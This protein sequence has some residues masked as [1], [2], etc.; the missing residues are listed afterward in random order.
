MTK[1]R[2]SFSRLLYNDKVMMI[3]SLL[4]AIG[5]WVS[6]IS[7]PANIDERTIT[8]KATIDLTNRSDLR[9]IGENEFDIKVTVSGKWSV[10]TKLSEEDLRV[11]PDFTV[12]ITPGVVEIPIDVMRN[13]SETDYDILSVSPNSVTVTV[14]YWRE[15]V[16]FDIHTDVSSLTAVGENAMIGEPTI[17]P[18]VFPDGK[19][20]VSG[21]KTV[22]DKIDKLVAKVSVAEELTAQK[23]YAVPLTA[24][25][26]DGNQL[27]LSLCEIQNY[28]AQT[29]TLT[30]PIWEERHIE[31]GYTVKNLPE[32]FAQNELLTLEPAALDLIGPAEELNALQAEFSNLGTVDVSQLSISNDSIS[33]PLDIPQTVRSFGAAEAA[34]V[35]LN[36]DNLSQKTVSLR[37]TDE[38]AEVIGSLHGLTASVREQTLDNVL[39]V[40][41]SSA[42]HAISTAALSVKI[43]LGDNMTAGTK[44]YNARIVVNGYDDVWVYY[45]DADGLPLYVTLS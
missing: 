15:N 28:T 35:T 43:E 21:P 19:A 26:V 34:T 2:F 37:V 16:T 13:S 32:G 39:L 36:T 25:D 27:D 10:I 40:G 42:I 22:V 7:G 3:L 23:Q 20:V 14:D 38:N 6:V 5:I 41:D 31:L 24:L 45:G 4:L 8:V 30:V 44:Q 33:F 12:G 18:A 9:V 1:R 17:D 11:R 29:V